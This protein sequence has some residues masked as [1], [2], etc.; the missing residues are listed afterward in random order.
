[1][2]AS[3]RN[4]SQ[5][6]ATIRYLTVLAFVLTLL[7]GCSST[8]KLV[9]ALP[10][11]TAFQSSQTGIQ[12]SPESLSPINVGTSFIALQL[13]PDENTGVAINRANVR[14]SLAGVENTSTVTIGPVGD[15]IAA[16][17]G[18]DALNSLLQ[19]RLATPFAAGSPEPTAP[20]DLPAPSATASPTQP[21]TQ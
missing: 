10:P 3:R 17:G 4:L 9:E 16:A 14:A 21:D 5:S 19:S 13:P 20:I 6:A 2:N 12:F 7:V 18:P 15:Q 1:M 11:G 8:R